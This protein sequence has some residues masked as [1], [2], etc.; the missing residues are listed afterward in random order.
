MKALVAAFH[1]LLFLKV[2]EGEW[3]RANLF[4]CS[5]GNNN[6]IPKILSSKYLILYNPVQSPLKIDKLHYYHKSDRTCIDSHLPL[7]SSQTSVFASLFSSQPEFPNCPLYSKTHFY[8]H[9]E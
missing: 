5:T 1:V 6:H 2:P 7:F 9:W 4:L 8:N 3:D